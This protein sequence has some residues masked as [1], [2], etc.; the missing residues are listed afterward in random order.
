MVTCYLLQRLLFLGA[1]LESRGEVEK[2]KEDQNLHSLLFS[3]N[4]QSTHNQDKRKKECPLVL[5]HIWRLPYKLYDWFD[6]GG[7][8]V[9]LL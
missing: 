3:E 8:R 1:A 9:T 2:N 6:E 7:G 5:F 4:W